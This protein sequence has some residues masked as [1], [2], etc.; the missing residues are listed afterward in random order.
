[1]T[2][3]IENNTNK[4]KDIP[5]SWVRRI[6]IGKISMLHKAT[7]R[8]NATPVKISKVYFTKVAKIILKFVWNHKRPW[9]AKVRKKRKAESIIFPDF[10]LCHKALKRIWICE[11]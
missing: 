3:E 1:M 2:K 11:I 7:Y 9:I 8:F 10:Q 4:W 5:C 6:Y